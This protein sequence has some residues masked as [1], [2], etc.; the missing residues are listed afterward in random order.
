MSRQ[1]IKEGKKIT[2]TTNRSESDLR[3]GEAQ[4]AKKQESP[5]KKN[6]RLQRDLNP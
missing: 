4:K 3:S 2:K 6:E 5:E 1:V